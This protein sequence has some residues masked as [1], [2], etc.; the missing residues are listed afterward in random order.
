M[1]WTRIWQGWADTQS[2]DEL[3]EYAGYGTTSITVSNT[4][5]KTGSYSF[6]SSIQNMPRGKSSTLTQLRAG[7]FFNHNG[8]GTAFSNTRAIIFLIPSTVGDIYVGWHNNTG[9][10]DLVVNGTAVDSID[11]ALANFSTTNVWQHC[12]ITCKADA[13][14]GFVS[15]Y[16]D[17]VQVLSWTGNTG[18]S[19][20]GC[21][22]GGRTSGS[23]NSWNNY[24]YF[25]D[26]YLDSGSGE[27]DAAPPSLRFDWSLVDAAGSHAA[28]TPLAST[29][30][31]NVDDAAAHDSDTTYNSACAAG[32][33]DGYNTAAITVP[34][35]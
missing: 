26:F 15:F 25:D 13:V 1:T 31:S 35:G 27:A 24:M 16:I 3:Q 28:W 34:A 2:I 17:G 19:L 9:A 21:Y 14:S 4:K 10:L 6:R 8:V 11:V 12:G 30:I 7:A 32:L 33:K 20:D 29:N 22:C 23:F 18:T 5:A